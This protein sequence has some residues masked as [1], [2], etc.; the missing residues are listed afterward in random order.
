MSPPTAFDDERGR[1]EVAGDMVQLGR[2][3]ARIEIDDDGLHLQHVGGAGLTLLLD[4]AGD[5]IDRRPLAVRPRGEGR[6]LVGRG[7]VGRDPDVVRLAVPAL[8]LEIRC[9][10]VYLLIQGAY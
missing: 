6:E 10:E 1:A 2:D 9:R 3:V 5:D 8:T 7:G 4:R